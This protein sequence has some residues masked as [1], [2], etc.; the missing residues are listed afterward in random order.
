MDNDFR[1][2][3][4]IGIILF[5]T[6]KDKD[7]FSWAANEY[8]SKTEFKK[9]ISA[10]KLWMKDNSKGKQALINSITIQDV[11]LKNIDL[12][13]C[14]IKNCT[15]HNCCFD[16]INLAESKI[17]RSAFFGC[18]LRDSII[19]N[20]VLDSVYF[21]ECDISSSD[22][23]NSKV[24]R[25]KFENCD[26]RWTNLNFLNIK[27]TELEHVNLSHSKEQDIIFYNFRDTKAYYYD[28]YI[29]IIMGFESKSLTV[30]ECIQMY[31]SKPIRYLR[32]TEED[33]LMIM[34]WLELIKKFMNTNLKRTNKCQ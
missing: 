32:W 1:S 16:G 6:Y 10:H 5:E 13:N 24:N 2:T 14:I 15:F 4:D 9:I 17:N 3:Q 23:S 26:L 20:S 8:I 28:G 22:L 11:M 34:G 19:S 27:N 31:R 18:N 21:N 25:S 33:K 29:N 7:I 30:D 12:T